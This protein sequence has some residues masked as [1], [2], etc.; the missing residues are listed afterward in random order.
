MNRSGKVLCLREDGSEGSTQEAAATI[1]VFCAIS[2]Y[3]SAQLLCIAAQGFYKLFLCF[4]MS[5]SD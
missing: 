4:C 1:E 5:G 3:S 2:V